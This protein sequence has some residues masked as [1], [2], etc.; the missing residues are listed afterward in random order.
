M[1]SKL[2]DSRGLEQMLA[3]KEE[4]ESVAAKLTAEPVLRK[5]LTARLPHRQ[6]LDSQHSP[7]REQVSI[8]LQKPSEA[9]IQVTMEAGWK[10]LTVKLGQ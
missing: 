10:Q 1:P 7:K 2:T 8:H 4:N 6:I 3:R 5:S 9:S